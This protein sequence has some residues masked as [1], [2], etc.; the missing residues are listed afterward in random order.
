MENNLTLYNLS[1]EMAEIENALIE[2]GGELTPELEEKLTCTQDALIK[3]AD[4]YGVIIE[5][6]TA[7]IANCKT[8]IDRINAIKKVADNS[9]KS[10]KQYLA[11]TMNTFGMKSLEGNLHKFSLTKTTATEVD[12]DVLLAPYKA[13][14]D[15]MQEKLP[16][17]ITIDAKI[18]KSDLKATYKDKDVT[19]DGLTFVENNSLRIR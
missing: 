9:L 17:W 5:K 13:L 2:N 6:F 10:I 12:E 14:L 19:L 7:A 16:S 11:D 1:A 3:K 18:S 4:S 15:A 8:E